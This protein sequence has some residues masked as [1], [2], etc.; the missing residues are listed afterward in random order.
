MIDHCL[1]DFGRVSAWLCRFEYL[2]NS[3]TT[4]LL[5]VRSFRPGLPGTVVPDS[6]NLSTIFETVWRTT[7][8]VVLSLIVANQKTT[9][10]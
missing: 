1:L 8:T 4:G 7:L 5:T 10:Q 9:D 2:T 3:T 6:T